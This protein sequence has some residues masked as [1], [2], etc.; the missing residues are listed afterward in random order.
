MH[1]NARIVNFA[2]LSRFSEKCGR[3]VDLNGGD[4]LLNGEHFVNK[5]HSAV[6]I[7][8]WVKFYSI[9]GMNSVFDTIG[10]KNSSHVMGQYHIEVINGSVRWFHRNERGKIIFNVLTEVI[11]PAHIW[12]HIACTYDSTSGYA[13]VFVNAKFVMREEG[14]GLLSQDW[15]VKAGIGEHKG[16]RLLDGLIDEFYISNEALMQVEIK[17]LMK[18]CEFEKGKSYPTPPSVG[19]REERERV[20]SPQKSKLTNCHQTHVRF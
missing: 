9:E 6:T 1:N 19:I 2:R 7:A 12:T 18:R 15:Q 4:I 13:Q 20:F 16:E 5:P 10:G 14:S 17:K 11:V 8:T 3:G